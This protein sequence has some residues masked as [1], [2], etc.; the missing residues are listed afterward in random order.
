[1]RS[2]LITAAVLAA[3]V[4]GFVV[5][6][7]TQKSSVPVVKKNR[8]GPASLPALRDGGS[9]GVSGGEGGWVQ[10][11]DKKTGELTNEFR[12]DHFDPPVNNRVHVVRPD[13]RFYSKDG[14]VLT[15]SASKGDITMAESARKTDKL[16]SMQGQPPSH[17]VL[18]DVKLGL[19]ETIDD[20][21]PVIT[22]TLPIV[23][24]DN[25]TLRLNTI[26][27]TVN[28]QE[29]PAD[30]IPVTVRGRDYDFDGQ[31]LTIR[32]N[33]RDR[34]LEFLEVAHGKRLVIKNPKAFGGT[35]QGVGGSPLGATFPPPAGPL[36]L[37]EGGRPIELASADPE[38][39]PKLSAEERER[40]RQRREAQERRAAREKRLAATQQ[41]ATKPAT[42]RPHEAVAYQATFSDAVTITEGGTPVGDAD[43]MVATFTF[44]QAAG[45][46]TKPVVA[47][48]G[49]ADAATQPV[50][51]RRP[52]TTTQSTTLPV[53]LPTS[54]A[55]TQPA[56][57]PARRQR[58]ATTSPTTGPTG[59]I[60][61][62][63]TGKL[64]VVPQKL[65][66]SGLRSS[67]DRIVE[68]TGK[69]VH[70]QRDGSTIVAAYIWAAIDGNRFLARPDD[71]TPL[72]TLTD[73]RGTVLKT[74]SIEADG[75]DA[76]LH[77]KSS[78]EMVLADP[79]Q[80]PKHL[81]TTWTEL[82][83]I[84]S[85]TLPG[86]QRGIERASFRGNVTVDHPQLKMTSDTLALGFAADTKTRQ[87]QLSAVRADGKVNA[88]VTNEDG[89]TQNIAANTL[90][91][92]T[93]ANAD[94]S[95]AVRSLHASG[96]V[97]AGDGRQ[98]LR[99]D[100]LATQLAATKIDPK[101]GPTA[102][103]VDSL[104]ATG[105]INF[106]TADGSHAT[107]DLL[108]IKT[109]SGAQWV[110]I[111]G[112]PARV[113]DPQQAISGSTITADTA[114][115]RANIDGP[116]TLKGAAKTADGKPGQPIDVAWT[117]SM[118]FDGAA[119]A[120]TIRGNVVVTSKGDDG[121]ISTA[122]GRTLEIA[123]VNAPTTQPAATTKPASTQPFGIAG[124]AGKQLKSLTL[125]GTDAANP[126][127]IS[128]LLYSATEPNKIIRRTYVW[129]P[130]ITVNANPDGTPGAIDVPSPGTMLYEDITPAVTTPNGT[131]KPS[132]GPLGGQG[133]VAL[134]WKKRMHY[135][136]AAQQ[137]VL[138]G[139]VKVVRRAPGQD[140][141]TML[142]PRLIAEVTDAK[143]SPQGAQ[144]KRLT[145]DQGATMFARK[146]R[147]D[148]ARA[149]YEPANDRL[150]ATGTPRESV[151]WF[152]ENGLSR[153]SFGEMW[154][155]LKTN[156][157]E[158]VKDVSVE[159]NR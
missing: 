20:T 96:N 109:V 23:A 151:K 38:A 145:A 61:I 35:S 91:L 134:E 63:W 83:N 40:R 154:W 3:L 84:R 93:A 41:A 48:A 121:T 122:K 28:G 90:E 102:M 78:A 150:I 152:D 2:V 147:V 88:A 156:Q 120:A 146:M 89:S 25:D 143:Q 1:M 77:G 54:Q 97:V 108:E 87:S 13:A 6:L 81:K 30:E 8:G 18:Y 123:F 7:L 116:G 132:V 124:G 112:T 31:G 131:T 82:A 68:F 71:T 59:P 17:G 153:G 14:S 105:N 72:V 99:A 62:K 70:L 4:A 113:S 21:V 138:E 69:P 119:N 36:L 136:P 107:G 92:G 39:A 149:V 127:E 98:T 64:T 19:L 94:G 157:P 141:A 29:I 42:S 46:T 159:V 60:E 47:P 125:I 148:A 144:L 27:L 86:G 101:A 115:T 142:A 110:S 57:R 56:T 66:D 137:A 58:A 32:Y 117:D 16:G 26:P 130:A 76:I 67:T 106:A 133:A 155:N 22:C 126:V 34:R 12:A 85:T 104:K 79:Q 139:D 80:Q 128:S 73:P 11:F 118:N 15:L 95:L 24:F 49:S 51:H 10:S 114:G 44:D 45:S 103:A 74:E 100:D 9:G 37:E 43:R 75:A 55:S 129:A 53:V 135:D 158:K 33:Q 65:V 50:R 52:T 140:E 111:T 5:F